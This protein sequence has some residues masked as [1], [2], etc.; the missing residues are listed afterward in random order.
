VLR[1]TINKS[2][3]V[4]RRQL[5]IYPEKDISELVLALTD[6]RSVCHYYCRFV[7][8]GTLKKKE[9]KSNEVCCAVC[10]VAKEREYQGARMKR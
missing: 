4:F 2:G 5:R 7:V 3:L 10:F 1:F 8:C 9:K 6:T